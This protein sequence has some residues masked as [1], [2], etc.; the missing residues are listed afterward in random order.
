[1]TD[2]ILHDSRVGNGWMERLWP[3]NG[4]RYFGYRDGSRVKQQDAVLHSGVSRTQ[5]AKEMSPTSRSP[6]VPTAR[7]WAWWT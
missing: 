2:P 1:M 7:W 6:A 4:D 3:D 5:R